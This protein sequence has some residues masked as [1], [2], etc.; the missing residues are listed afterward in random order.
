[1]D[2]PEL[3]LNI[4]KTILSNRKY[5]LD[6]VHENNEK[7]FDSSLWRFAKNVLELIRIYKEVPSKRVILE[8]LKDQKNASFIEYMNEVFQKLETV[9]YDE[10]DYKHDLEKL[11]NRYSEKLISTFKN[12]L[13]EQPTIDIKKSVGEMQSILGNLKNLN[14]KR[15]YKD[16]SLKD[17]AEDFKKFYAAK[18][19]NPDFGAGIKTGYSFID[20]ATGGLKAGEL[21][22]FAGITSSG[23]SLLL[24]NTAIQMWLGDNNINRLD[25]FSKGCNVLLFSLEMNYEDYMQR[26]LARI[27]MVPQKSIRD[28]ILTTEEK[29]QVS[30][31]FKFIKAYPYSF[32]VIDLPRKATA[33][34]IEMIINEQTELGVK[35]DVVVIDY[36]NLMHADVGGEQSDWLIQSAISEHCHELARVKEVMLLSAVQLNPKGEGGKDFSNGGVRNFRRATQIADNADFIICINSRKD[37]KNYPDFSCSFIKNRRGDLIDGKLYKKM[38]CCALIDKKVEND[39]SDP[40]DISTSM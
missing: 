7:L 24:M 29:E 38:N 2:F 27:A 32:K 20:F 8:R 6:F 19:A 35:P 25:N 40:E 1:M 23:K 31:A 17:Y 9:K 30:K 3:D 22:L 14:Q 36:M 34:T 10:K 21:L 37:E 5:A 18:L 26:A 39:G 33:E 11:K 4:L 16:G 28:A 12:N 13:V 15:S